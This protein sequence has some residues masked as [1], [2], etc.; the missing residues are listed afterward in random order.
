MQLHFIWVNH[1]NSLKKTGINLSSQFLISL[2]EKDGKH[3]VTIDHNNNYISDFIEEKNII[4]VNAIIGKNGA[5]KSSVLRYIKNHLPQGINTRIKDDLFI[6][7]DSNSDGSQNFFIALPQSMSLELINNTSIRFNIKTYKNFRDIA[8][9]NCTYIYYQYLLEYNEDH[10]NWGGLNN[11]ST[12]AMLQNERVR[13]LLDI[14][15]L[16]NNQQ[17]LMRTTDLEFLYL[18]EV[19]QAIV[20]ITHSNVKLPFKKPE[21]LLVR[22][23]DSERNYFSIENSQHKDV[24][25][26]LD[27]LSRIA[28]KHRDKNKRFIS[29]LLEAILLNFLITDRK[30]SANNPY[31]YTVKVEDGENRDE[32]ILRFFQS[33][34]NFSY[35]DENR[36]VE[37]GIQRFDELS[38]EV[39]YFIYLV[40]NMLEKGAIAVNKDRSA[41]FKLDFKAEDDFRSFQQSYIRVKGMVPFLNFRWR[42]L[43]SG[44][45]SYLSFISRFYSLVHDRSNTLKKDLFIMIDEG[46]TGYHPDWQRKFFKNTLKFLSET[47]I[48]HRIQVI[49]T[50]NTPFLT[51]D[52]LKSNILFTQKSKNDSS[53][54]LSK[55]NSNESTFAA[56]IHTLFSDSFYMDGVLI[57][58]YAKEKIN[59]IIEYINDPETKDPKKNYKIIIDNIGEPILR[60]KLQ[61]MW[62][63]KFGLREELELLK[64]RIREV[65]EELKNTKISTQKKK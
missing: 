48:D 50:S 54:F 14:H 17:L 29:E 56:N 22:I 44:E 6:Y 30:Y 32:Y 37:I 19:L 13:L 59:K 57:G 61:D 63:E 36:K 24:Y 10:T 8:P 64:K 5:G 25:E 7:S 35:W 62:Q 20:F 21:S 38:Q 11:I 65:E 40:S 12:S 43:S 15:S 1:Y 39:P 52:L 53:V 9:N 3:V 16:Q 31:Q 27:V 45:Q 34:K 42:S 2:I 55:D 47:F 41:S 58:E 4:N 26:L 23:D 49:F 18:Q 60:K 28:P 33:M 51:S 46:D